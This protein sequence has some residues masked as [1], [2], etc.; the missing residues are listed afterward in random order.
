MLKLEG[1]LL[2]RDIIKASASD[3]GVD[4]AYYLKT[5][6]TMILILVDNVVIRLDNEMGF[7]NE[8]VVDISKE[9]LGL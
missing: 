2:Y 7:S 5:D 3:W 4:R 8:D 1:S 9:Q 6:K